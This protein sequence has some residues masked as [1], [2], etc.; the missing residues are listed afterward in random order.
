MILSDKI[1][2][3]IWKANIWFWFQTTELWY[4]LRLC[5]LG[6]MDGDGY[7]FIYA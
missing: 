4:V 7:H 2:F 3:H 6:E 5:Q 1:L